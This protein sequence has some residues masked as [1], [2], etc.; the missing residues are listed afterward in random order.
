MMRP[1]PLE[2]GDSA[3]HLSGV[4][5]GRAVLGMVLMLPQASASGGAMESAQSAANAQG[6]QGTQSYGVYGVDSYFKVEWQL[7][8]RRGK[9]MVSGYV[10]NQWGMGARNVRL[11][12][13]ALDAAGAVVATYIGY[14]N[15]DAA[16]G[17][18]IYFE[19]PVREKAPNYHVNVLS[20]DP[21]EG[22]G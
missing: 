1:C 6:G 9:P 5:R 21:V 3:R 16:P 17:A 14:V 19:V 10:R 8:E 4:V 15:G 11:R 13:E 18:H 2:S 7:D 12:V 22:H 20:F